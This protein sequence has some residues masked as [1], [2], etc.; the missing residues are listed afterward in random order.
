M[1][2]IIVFL[3][4]FTFLTL[5]STG[6]AHAAGCDIYYVNTTDN[7]VRRTTLSRIY[8][9]DAKC[10]GG[11]KSMRLLVNGTQVLEN[12]NSG[13]IGTWW[14]A[15]TAGTYTICF[16]ATGANDDRAER[17]VNST[18][19]GSTSTASVLGTTPNN[20]VSPTRFQDTTCPS[21]VT[22]RLR[23]GGTGHTLTSVNVRA[24]SGI[25]SLRIGRLAPGTSFEVQSDPTCNGGINW[26]KI[27]IQ[28]F[29]G[30]IA[31]S[32]YG[33]YLLSP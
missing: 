12:K 6:V 33:L 30:M 22:A 31:E 15:P 16:Q 24:A 4:V 5:I 18:G 9:A 10:D 14:K 7:F 26:W 20:S 19:K 28:E 23:N 27:K 13:H 21:S 25:S 2:K 3:S 8:S 32:Q 17:C 1:N 11:I 29:T